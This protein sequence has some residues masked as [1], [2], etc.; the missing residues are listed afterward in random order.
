MEQMFKDYFGINAIA[1]GACVN[2]KTVEAWF[3]QDTERGKLMLKTPREYERSMGILFLEEFPK[4]FQIISKLLYTKPDS[5][6]QWRLDNYSKPLSSDLRQRTFQGVFKL[7]SLVKKGIKEH[8]KSEY[9]NNK[10]LWPDPR[11]IY[12]R[13]WREL[14]FLME[15]Q[16]NQLFDWRVNELFEEP[17]PEIASRKPKNFRGPHVSR[18]TQFSDEYRIREMSYQRTRRV[19]HLKGYYRIEALEKAEIADDLLGA[20]WGMRDEAFPARERQ[21]TKL[22]NEIY[23]KKKK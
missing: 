4:D 12:E 9:L 2:W 18:Y 10:I 6:Q 21:E 8:G 14:D 20:E 19:S 3:R 17:V 13:T 7:R 22:L 15:L 1:A 16:V 11:H 5:L 23:R